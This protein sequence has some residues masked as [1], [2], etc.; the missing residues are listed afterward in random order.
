MKRRFLIWVF[1]LISIILY[2]ENLEAYSTEVHRRITISVIDQN[3]QKLNSYLKDIGLPNGV[4]ELVMKKQVRKWIEHGSEWEDYDI[5]SVLDLLTSH[6]HNPLT[7]KGLTEGGITIGESAYDR[8]NNQTNYWGWKGA[9]E[10]FYI[11]LTSTI[12]NW[13]ETKLADSLDALV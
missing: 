6:Y 5:G 12:K 10:N 2:Q 4:T 7:N 13:R 9:R 3:I 11:G 1:I 8:A